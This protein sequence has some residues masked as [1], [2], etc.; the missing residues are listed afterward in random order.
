MKNVSI[1]IDIDKSNKIVAKWHDESHLNRWF[2]D[3]PPTKILDCGYCYSYAH[4]RNHTPRLIAID[5]DHKAFGNY[6]EGA[7]EIL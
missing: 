6:G 2:L 4:P 1:N 7:D 3:N 5:K